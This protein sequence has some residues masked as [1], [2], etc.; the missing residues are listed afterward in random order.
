MVDALVTT[1]GAIEEDIIKCITDFFLGDF[2]Y[3]GKSLR[4]N[5]MQRYGNVIGGNNAY[6]DFEDLLLPFLDVLLVDQVNNQKFI[7]ISQFIHKLG[8]IIDDENSICYW[9]AKVIFTW[10]G[11]VLLGCVLTRDYCSQSDVNMIFF[12]DS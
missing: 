1:C 5:G 6:C 2:S 7:S 12:R 4:S 11:N 8:E 10:D 3:S 9:A